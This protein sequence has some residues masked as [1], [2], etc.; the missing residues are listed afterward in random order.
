MRRSGDQMTTIVVGAG[1]SGLWLTSALTK[2]GEGRSV[3]CLE[4]GNV[5]GGRIRSI[6]GEAGLAYE[7]GPWR[8]PETHARVLRLFRAHAVPLEPLRTP[9]LPKIPLPAVTPG[10]S[11]WDVNALERGP[12]AA[13]R[14]DL[15]TG[16]A[17]QTHSASGS[18]PYTTDS[19]RYFV[20]RGGFSSLIDAMRAGLDVRLDHRVVDVTREDRGYTMHVVRRSDHNAFETITMHAD[21]L[22]VCVPPDVCRAWAIFEAHAKSV[23][24]AVE[25]GPLHHIYMK[26]PMACCI[27]HRHADSLLAQS[28]SSQYDNDWFQATY[29]GGRIARLWHRL[30]LSHPARFRERLCEEVSRVWGRLVRPEG[31]SIQ[32][33][34]WHTAFHHWKPVPEFDLSRAVHAAV[35]PSPHMLP[36]VFLAGEAFSSFQAW[37]E[38]ALETAE[39]ALDAYRADVQQLD[40]AHVGGSSSSGRVGDDAVVVYVEG[41]R[42][43]VTRWANVHPG[44]EMALRAHA[45]EDVTRLMKH[46]HHSSHAWAVVHALKCR[47]PDSAASRAP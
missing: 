36:N 26:A 14:A 39:L 7:A 21:V 44:G 42:I 8:I 45:G 35:R 6:T 33:H 16:Y 17:D 47:A 25:Q 46:V 4:R 43:D 27:H 3:V 32:S 1:L 30:G 40:R 5:C 13:D 24:N 28:I 12:M 10:M 18:A 11:M 34:F 19:S 31:V 38:G 22:F 37:M 9:T 2:K 41:H 15:E 23:M 29:S 20:A